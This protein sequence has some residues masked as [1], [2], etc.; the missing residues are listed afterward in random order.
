MALPTKVATLAV[1]T[2]RYA[3]TRASS[4]APKVALL[5][6]AGGIG[7]PLGLLLKKN[8]KI[9]SLSLYDIVGTPGVAAD[10]SHID[11]PAKVTAHTGPNE[12]A[13]ALEGADVIVIPAGVPRKP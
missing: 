2:L 12:L 7:Q 4:S 8:N 10:L 1:P 3:G 13:G 11:S 5:G 9:A 6:G